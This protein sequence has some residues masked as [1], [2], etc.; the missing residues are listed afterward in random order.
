MPMTFLGPNHL[1]V[2]HTGARVDMSA[3]TSWPRLAGAGGA[4]AASTRVG[5]RQKQ[6]ITARLENNLLAL[7]RP[8]IRVRASGYVKSFR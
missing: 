1:E 3:A 7:G 2:V 8:S 5:V 4:R 6:V